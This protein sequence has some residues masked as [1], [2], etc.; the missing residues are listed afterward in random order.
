MYIDVSQYHF[1]LPPQEGQGLNVYVNAGLNVLRRRHP[2]NDKLRSLGAD[3]VAKER[4]EE[5]DGVAR[6]QI[7]SPPS[8]YTCAANTRTK[9]RTHAR[10]RMRDS[11]TTRAFSS[12]RDAAPR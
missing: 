4:E 6:S 5:R 1:A 7:I 9:L 3:L 11:T 12:P 2:S 10:A 8:R